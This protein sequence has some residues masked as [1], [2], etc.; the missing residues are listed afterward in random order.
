MAHLKVSRSDG[1]SCYFI[2]VA[3][4]CPN[5]IYI[6][7][8]FFIPNFSFPA[9]ATEFYLSQNTF[10]DSQAVPLIYAKEKWDSEYAQGSYSHSY[11]WSETGLRTKHWGIGF[12]YRFDIQAKYNSDTVD[13]LFRVKNKREL[14]PEKEYRLNIDVNQ[15]RAFGSRISYRNI[16]SNL[17]YNIG[18]SILRAHTVTQGTLQGNA[19]ILTQKDYEF[20]FD[21]DYFYST[22]YLFDRQIQQPTGYGLSTDASFSLITGRYTKLSMQITD[23]VGFIYWSKTPRTVA[24]GDSS[25]RNYDENGYLRYEPYITGTESYERLIQLFT[26]RISL[27]ASYYREWFTAKGEIFYTSITSYLIPSVGTVLPGGTQLL[28]SRVL[29]TTATKLSVTGKTFAIEI[30][31]DHWDYQ[32]INS[33]GLSISYNIQLK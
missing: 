32:K 29:P 22:D 27:S 6:F 4:S 1:I 23:I 30:F 7:Y 33:A 26:P 12:L 2:G 17:H 13:F 11:I 24:A 9:S 21:T 18:V 14:I 19:K 5:F 25:V 8:L 20:E 31:S 16:H 10:S 28:I 15:L 3:K